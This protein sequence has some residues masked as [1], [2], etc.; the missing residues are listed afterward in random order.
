MN[1]EEWKQSFGPPSPARKLVNVTV[2]FQTGTSSRVFVKIG[3]IV[4]CILFL[5]HFNGCL[6][7][8][9]PMIQDFPAGSWVHAANILVG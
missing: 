9:V 6:L 1:Q 8:F 5:A 3:N 7:Y 4:V 2:A